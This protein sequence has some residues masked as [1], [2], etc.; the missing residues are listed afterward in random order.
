MENKWYQGKL[1]NF[2]E[3]IEIIKQLKLDLDNSES[4]DQYGVA[5]IEA[6]IWSD[7]ILN[8]A[9]KIANYNTV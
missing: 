5:C 7:K 8:N 9:L 4:L 6:L 1:Y 2:N 3:T